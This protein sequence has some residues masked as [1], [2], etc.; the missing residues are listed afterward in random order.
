[1][2]TRAGSVDGELCGA[3]FSSDERHRYRL[4]RFNR[5]ASLFGSPQTFPLFLMLNPSTATHETT[6]PTVTRCARFAWAWGF[7]RFDVCNLFSF[8]STDPAAL[9]REAGAEGD[10]NNIAE[11][12]RAAGEAETIV[13]AWGVHGALRDRGRLVLQ[14]LERAGHG[15]K[16][17]ALRLTREGYPGHPLYLPAE[18]R[19]VPF[20]EVTRG[21]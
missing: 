13:C 19:P 3:L 14:A 5:G 17:T 6:D 16:L 12:L 1:M 2:I 11:I 9:Y 7:G 8:R 20:R 18:L 10:P 4:W 21:R 15:S